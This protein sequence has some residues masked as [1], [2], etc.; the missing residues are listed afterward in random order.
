MKMKNLFALALLVLLV[1][2]AIAADP[3]GGFKGQN[4]PSPII[5]NGVPFNNTVIHWAYKDVHVLDPLF[6]KQYSDRKSVV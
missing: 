5:I 2:P 4:Y 1:A 6:D 3:I